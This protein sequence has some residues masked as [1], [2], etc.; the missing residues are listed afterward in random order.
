MIE[1]STID[2]IVSR[3]EANELDEACISQL[4]AEFSGLHFTWCMD[5]D[6]GSEVPLVERERFNIY[7][8]DGEGHCLKLTTD[9]S[10]ANGVVI[11]EVIAEENPEA[12]E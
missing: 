2:A 3:L 6:I 11:A 10:K 8:V 1:Q 7:L 5:D 9:L 12:N 4:R